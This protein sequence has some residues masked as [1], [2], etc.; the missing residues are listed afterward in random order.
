MIY[1]DGIDKNVFVEKTLFITSIFLL[2]VR[3]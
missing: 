3:L 1:I 2:F